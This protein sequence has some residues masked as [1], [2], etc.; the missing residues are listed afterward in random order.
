MSLNRAG[1]APHGGPTRGTSAVPRWRND[2]RSSP[3]KAKSS[4][5]NV[6]C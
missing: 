4:D 3:P 2:W 1:Q 6:A 5:P